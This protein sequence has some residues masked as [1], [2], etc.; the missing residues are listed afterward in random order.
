M[1][2]T[3]FVK[4]QGKLFSA[5]CLELDV[6]SQGKTF[7]Q[8]CKNL[9]EA[10]DLYLED[11]TESHNPKA[12]LRRHAPYKLWKEYY[13]TRADILFQEVKKSHHPKITLQPAFCA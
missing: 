1:Q 6:A 5:I 12:F 8:A 11:V 3:C 10:I 9:K 4:K 7:E 2:L 13:K